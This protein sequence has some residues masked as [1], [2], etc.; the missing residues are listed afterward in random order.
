VVAEDADAVENKEAVMSLRKPNTVV[1]LMVVLMVKM[2]KI[3]KTKVVVAEDALED[4]EAVM[5][6]LLHLPLRLL[7]ALMVIGKN[8]AQLVVPEREDAIDVKF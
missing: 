3:L 7:A 6:L 4:K 8:M 1:V 5:P 2:M